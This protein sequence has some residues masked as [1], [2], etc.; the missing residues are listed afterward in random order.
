MDVLDLYYVDENTGQII[1]NFDALALKTSDDFVRLIKEEIEDIKVLNFVS[2]DKKKIFIV[3]ISTNIELMRFSFYKDYGT[4]GCN[5][6][7]RD[8][9]KY[10]GIKDDRDESI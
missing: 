5:L 10:W 2:R 9:L 6:V 7:F 4:F 8:D 1:I 3:Y